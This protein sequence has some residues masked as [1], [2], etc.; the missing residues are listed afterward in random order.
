MIMRKI[1]IA[2]A[3]VMIMLKIIVARTIVIIM[4]K[5]I[6]TRA[7]VMIM[8]KIVVALDVCSLGSV[9]QPPSH[10]TGRGDYFR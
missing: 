5:I 8:L 1:V 9:P 6:I 7:I 4:L 10:P 2:G 3:T